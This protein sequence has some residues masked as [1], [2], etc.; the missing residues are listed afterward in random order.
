MTA[1]DER[2]EQEIKQLLADLDP[3]GP[4]RLAYVRKAPAGI[5]DRGG[6][7]LCL[8]ASF[9]PLTTAHV[10][11]I[12]EA[13]RLIPPDEI[14]LLLARANVDKL[15]A[16][17]PLERR[18]LLLKRFAEARANFS[19]AATHH[20]RFVDKVPAIR[21]HYP[22]TIRL[23]FILGFDTL[24]RLFDRKYYTD[25]EAA[26]TSLFARSDIIAANRAPEPPEAVSSFLGRSDVAQY[27]ARI[28]IIRLPDDIAAISA[29]D[30]RARLAR[31][32]P[33]AHLVPPEILPLLSAAPP[34]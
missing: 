5:S 18:L 20:G 11:L 29:T 7:L 2:D 9:N 24:I 27:A 23:S 22:E 28:R 3:N 8:S 6:T 21:R 33:A 1:R 14:L 32:E 26:L 19:A 12:Q 34:R 10:C 15:A 4:P 31:G 13:S 16:G 25:C 30:V 17:F